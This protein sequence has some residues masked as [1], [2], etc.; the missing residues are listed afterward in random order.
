MIIEPTPT[1]PRSPLRRAMRV[2]GIVLPVVLLA[3]V[4]G[5]GVLG[6]RPEPPALEASPGAP[7]LGDASQLADDPSLTAETAPP[8][9]IPAGPVPSFPTVAADL[10]VLAVPAAQPRLAGADGLPIA[11]AGYL[12]DVS[13]PAACAAAMGDTRRLLSPLCE[14]LARLITADQG[15]ADPGV[16]LHVRI[17]PGVRLPPAFEDAGPDEPMPVVIVGRAEEPG[18]PCTS[19]ARGCGERLVADRVTWAN[20]AA[21]DPGPV[22]DA[23]LETPPASVAYRRLDEAKTLAVGWSGTILVAAVVRPRTVAEIDPAAAAAMAAGPRPQELVWYVRGLETGY[24]PTRYPLGHAPPRLSWA[25]VDETTGATLARGPVWGPAAFPASVSG[26]P[27]LGVA[28]AVEARRAGLAPDVVAVAGWLRAWADPRACTNPID[29]LPGGGCPR[30][31]MLVGGP[32][33]DR[34]SSSSSDVGPRL[35]SIV[36][37]GVLIPDRAVGLAVVDSGPPPP[38][39]VLGRFGASD[40]GCNRDPRECTEPFTIEAV[41]WSSG[42]N[43]APGRQVAAGLVVPVD[44]VAASATDPGVGP[45]VGVTRLLRVVLARASDLA[46]LDPAAALALHP[47]G[48][49]PS[50]PVWYVRGLA[51]ESSAISWAVVEPGTG[52]VLARDDAG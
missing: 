37:P 8:R 13:G 1:N 47:A 9:Q 27:V 38:V 35:N 23:G 41:A 22:F 32:W 42:R 3:A 5:A 4:I 52:R 6:P 15:A 11:V 29:G 33:T 36:P 30:A 18:A 17:P 2:A 39:V 49:R 40:A 26:L 25:V 50:A 7:P 51:A 21:F 20:G 34:A 45:P 12:S 48:M 43:L 28:E 14:R 19:S 44:L 10:E 16:H 31:A 24:D 46:A